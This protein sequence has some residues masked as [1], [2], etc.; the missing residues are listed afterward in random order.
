MFAADW[1]GGVSND[2]FTPGNWSGTALPASGEAVDVGGVPFTNAPV[3][4]GDNTATPAG[5]VKV[6][7][8]SGGAFTV[9]GGTFGA[10]NMWLGG[11]STAPGSPVPSLTVNG[12]SIAVNAP[13]DVNAPV[14]H[15]LCLW[16][17]VN[18]H[19]DSGR[20]ERVSRVPRW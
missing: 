16:R 15:Q 14:H 6:G 2:Y 19:H 3:Y 17:E 20:S 5:I 10:S 8:A 7:L 13:F 11:V 1:I 18:L 9:N 12:G 4:A